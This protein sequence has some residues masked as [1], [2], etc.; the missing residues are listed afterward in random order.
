MVMGGL[1]PVG[2]VPLLWPVFSI[3][4]VVLMSRRRRSALEEW[5]AKYSGGLE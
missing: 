1:E 2:L 4:L 5:D 3:G